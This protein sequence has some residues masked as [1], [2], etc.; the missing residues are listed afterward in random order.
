MF[1]S[2]VELLEPRQFLLPY[3]LDQGRNLQGS[4]LPMASTLILTKCRKFAKIVTD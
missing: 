4:M 2:S 3:V 1:L